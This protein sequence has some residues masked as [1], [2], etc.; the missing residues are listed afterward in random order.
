MNMLVVIL[1]KFC[2]DLDIQRKML[3]NTELEKKIHHFIYLI[4]KIYKFS[5]GCNEIDYRIDF[6]LL[7]ILLKTEELINFS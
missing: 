6:L 3:F 2:N 1:Y 5:D 7:I 4:T